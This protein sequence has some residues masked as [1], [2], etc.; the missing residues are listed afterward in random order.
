MFYRNF[1]SKIL[2]CFFILF[3]RTGYARITHGG[4]S[5]T[6]VQVGRFEIPADPDN[7][8]DNVR[9]TTDPDEVPEHVRFHSRYVFLIF[10]C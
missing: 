6:E 4:L 10:S 8:E 9:T 3:S 5:D 2:V 1:C 7:Y